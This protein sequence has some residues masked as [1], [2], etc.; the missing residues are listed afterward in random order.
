[1]KLYAFA[2]AAITAAFIL[3]TNTVGASAAICRT[4]PDENG[5]V[6]EY[7]TGTSIFCIGTGVE[8]VPSAT[9]LVRA[10]FNDIND[11]DLYARDNREMMVSD[12]TKME[13]IN[14]F[15]YCE[16]QFV[17]TVTTELSTKVVIFR[18]YDENHGQYIVYTFYKNVGNNERERVCGFTDDNGSS[19]VIYSDGERFSIE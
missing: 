18:P 14:Q 13:F 11:I 10:A 8:Y 15:G 9:E 4:E 5:D 1:M 2:V 17:S 3:A 6:W 7:S 12:S 16:P 19:H